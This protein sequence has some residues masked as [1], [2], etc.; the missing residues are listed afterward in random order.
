MLENIHR[1]LE[2]GTSITINDERD[3]SFAKETVR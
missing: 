3:L 2:H 1:S